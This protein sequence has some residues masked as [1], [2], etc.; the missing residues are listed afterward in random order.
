MRGRGGSSKLR[1][2][3]S[4]VSVLSRRDRTNRICWGA[5]LLLLSISAGA[6]RLPPYLWVEFIFVSFY[7]KSSV[8]IIVEPQRSQRSQRSKGRRR[9]SAFRNKPDFRHLGESVFCRNRV[10]L[11]SK[12]RSFGPF[13]A[14][15]APSAALRET[16]NEESRFHAGECRAL[17]VFTG[18]RSWHTMC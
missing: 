3:L 5:P 10:R 14:F 4:R 15:S 9:I 13:S 7:L 6:K 17:R 2:V 8:V 18:N 1:S 16:P 12:S 11:R